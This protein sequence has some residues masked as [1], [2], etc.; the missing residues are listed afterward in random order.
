MRVRAGIF[1]QLKTYTARLW[2]FRYAVL[3]T[4]HGRMLCAGAPRHA[5]S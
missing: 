4:K 1:Y 3:L 5:G 2:V